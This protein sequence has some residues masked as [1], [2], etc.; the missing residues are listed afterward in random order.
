MLLVRSFDKQ[1][2][3]Q[4]RIVETLNALCPAMA[5]IPGPGLL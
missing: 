1:A 5:A 4:P 2:L 3:D